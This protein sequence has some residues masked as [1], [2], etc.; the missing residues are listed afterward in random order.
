MKTLK[1]L[2]TELLEVINGIREVSEYEINIQNYFYI[3][4]KNYPKRKF[5][6]SYSIKRINYLEINKLKPER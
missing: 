4:T 1:D 3:V 2:Q 5:K 6:K